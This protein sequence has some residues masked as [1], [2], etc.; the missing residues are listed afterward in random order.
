MLNGERVLD[1]S[2]VTSVEAFLRTGETVD[3][4]YAAA[5][6]C[7]TVYACVRLL[8]DAIASL[9]LKLIKEAEDGRREPGVSDPLYWLLSTAPCPWMDKIIYWKFNLNCLLRADCLFLTSSV[10]ATAKSSGLCRSTRCGSMSRESRFPRRASCSFRFRTAR[11][12]GGFIRPPS[13]FSA[14]T[15]RLDGIRPVTPIRYARETIRLARNAEKYGNDTLQNGAVLPGYY[16]SENKIGQEAFERLR[17]SFPKTAS[18]RI[19]ARRRCWTTGCITTR[20]R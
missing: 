20:C 5:K 2:S 8:S 1:P 9:P 17:L 16:T 4:A 12:T 10:P 15:K 6:R 14:T 3:T 18:G 11:G 19:P 13:C 7:S